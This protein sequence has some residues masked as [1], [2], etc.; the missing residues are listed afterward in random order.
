MRRIIPIMLTIIFITA[1]A[2][3][4]ATP[5]VPDLLTHTTINTDTAIP[6][7][8]TATATSTPEPTFTPTPV[9][10]PARWYWVEDAETK[11]L[12]AINQD[13][14]KRGIGTLSAEEVENSMAFRVDDGRAFLITISK[15]K[16]N[17][18]LLTLDGM[19]PIQMPDSLPFNE[20]SDSYWAVPAVYGDRLIFSYLTD[21]SF[22]GTGSTTADRGP[23][24]LVDLKTL[25]A[26][27]LD[28]RVH[29]DVFTGS[30]DV[31][32][33]AHVSQDGRYVRYLNGDDQELS[34][35]EVD[36]TVG[37]PRT[38]HT[39]SGYVTSRIVPSLDG[40]MWWFALDDTM[41]D[42]YGNQFQYTEENKYMLPMRNG[43][44][45][46][47]PTDCTDNCEVEVVA[48]FS[49][50]AGTRYKLPWSPGVGYN[51]LIFQ[52]TPDQNL[53]FLARPLAYLTD[54]P[55]LASQI[56]DLDDFDRPVFRLSPDGE[57]KVIGYYDF[58]MDGIPVSSDGQY[59][60]LRSPDHTSILIYD[61]FSDRSLAELPIVPE[62]DYFWAG[63][64][65][66]EDGIVAHVT[67]SA[68]DKS[69]RDFIVAYSLLSE[70][71]YT[72]E[73]GADDP[74]AGCV[75]LL[76]DDSLI[77]EMYNNT[78]EQTRIVR[79]DPS[80]KE[81]DVLSANTWFETWLP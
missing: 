72:W 25:T 34:V 64:Q 20:M 10:P 67:A 74:I 13:G 7:A 45:L 12:M 23:F 59:M 6:M 29:H 14:E 81:T 32:T 54:K 77:C 27:L 9:P 15:S 40:D 18:Y 44:A 41:I 31:R 30:G 19:Q 58:Y 66:F 42:L 39:V 78:S 80:T 57:A 76:P 48:A 2:G 79:Y 22:G 4:A 70:R 21:Q 55:A 11:Q 43:D 51:P 73:T 46:V 49:G 52:V 71:S 50:A 17:A 60:L 35:R 38:V 47:V 65:F 63:I 16:F 68:P 61:M 62:L 26:S 24:V 28:E 3:T 37:E 69:Y 1:C 53:I 8:D 5:S 36:L 56:T 33:W 75:D